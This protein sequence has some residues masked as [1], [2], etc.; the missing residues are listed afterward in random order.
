MS[1]LKQGLARRLRRVRAIGH[2]SVL[3][4]AFGL[5]R[6]PFR[7]I[8]LRIHFDDGLRNSGGP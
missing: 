3:T 4:R 5:R 8:A 2:I 6:D 1:A 7:T